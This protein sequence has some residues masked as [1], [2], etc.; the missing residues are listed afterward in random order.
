M[1]LYISFFE[2]N[3][4]FNFFNL[5]TSSLT[6]FDEKKKM[7]VYFDESSRSSAIFLSLLFCDINN[8]INQ[9]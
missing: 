9:F 6:E 4:A 5:F 8:F 7:Y 3:G 1:V 2:R